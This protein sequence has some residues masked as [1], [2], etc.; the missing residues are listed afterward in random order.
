MED[1]L[2]IT[3]AGTYWVH[4]S[5]ACSFVADTIVITA[6]SDPPVINLPSQIQLCLDD[7]LTLDAGIT[8]VSYLWS[9]LSQQQQ[10]VVYSPGVFSLTVTNACGTDVDTVHVL[11]GG[12]APGVQLGADIQLCPGTQFI[13]DPTDEHVHTWLWQDGTTLPT[14]T[15]SAA[16][17]IIVSVQNDCGTAH[18]TL[19]VTMLPPVPLVNLGADT[20]ICA[21]QTY[22]LSLSIPDVSVLWQDGS[23]GQEFT[24]VQPGTVHVTIANACG[25]HS[26]TVE[27]EALPSIPL[28]DL[29][30]DQS[31]CPGELITVSPGIDSVE[32]VWQDGSTGTTY[33]STLPGMIILVISN[34]CGTSTDTLEII[35]STEGPDVNLGPDI[36]ACEGSTVTIQ[37]D[38]SGVMFEWQDGSTLP[39]YV[40]TQSGV[41]ILAV[42]NNCGE[43]T[44]T[45]VVDMTGTVPLVALGADTLL[46]DDASLVLYA[47]TD[48]NTDVVWQDGSV[49]DSFL[50]HNAGEYTLTAVNQCGEASDTILITVLNS[51]EVFTLGPDTGL[52]SQ[53]TIV[54]YVPDT[55]HVW[56][57]QDGSVADSLL[58][59]EA[60]AYSLTT[61]NV[62]GQA[63]DE[64]VITALLAPEPFTL[65]PDTV[66]CPDETIVLAVPDTNYTWVWSDGFDLPVRLITGA[67]VFSLAISNACGLVS[68]TV[69]I[70]RDQR[71][72]EI[73]L[74][75]TILWCVDD[76]IALDVSQ[77]FV[78]TYQWSTG[79][80]SSTIVITEPGDYHVS[81]FAPCAI[82]E[83]DIAVVPDPGCIIESGIYIPNVFSPNGDQVNDVFTV[84]VGPFITI[85]EM[86]GTVYDRWGNV[87]FASSSIPFTWDGR[88]AGEQMMPGVYVYRVV[89]RYQVVGNVYE[90]V[91]AGDVTLIR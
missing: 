22:T 37:S 40:V 81:V 35:E 1:S 10:I 43:D 39:E 44:D 90:E 70:V 20:A 7:S 4:A 29:G 64:I 85:L 2:V 78:A 82:Q 73:V 6:N 66:L 12:P 53:E 11:D 45:I 60:G 9:D 42:S 28:L 63:T 61:E 41:Y 76:T 86:D 23:T 25:Q 84:A 51:P 68:D 87:V 30:I 56:Q 75:P 18:D 48:V 77:T 21:Q 46:C 59:V 50:L 91:F 27:I 32:Y 69:V 65:G 52:C 38:I 15:V 57:W 13:I 31:L 79:E 72:P 5:N 71:V 80:T 14:Y 67:G 55:D 54:L 3:T 8:G 74:D 24:V 47:G 49:A 89:C 17:T 34:A 36:E 58:V 88:F 83:A 33:Q 19:E 16:D 26:D 62:C